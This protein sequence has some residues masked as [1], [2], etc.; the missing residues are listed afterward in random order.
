MCNNFNLGYFTFLLNKY[1]ICFIH[2]RC[3]KE[4]VEIRDG[5][6][7]LSPLIGRYCTSAP[8][9]QYST[10]NMIFIKFFT[11]TDEP[12]NGFKAKISL[13][14]CGGTLRGNTGRI[15]FPTPSG[16]HIKERKLNCTWHIVGPNDHYLEIKITKLDMNC[17]SSAVTVYDEI[18]NFNSSYN[19]K[20]S[21]YLIYAFSNIF[22]TNIYRMYIIFLK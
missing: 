3:K 22:N 4:Y 20:C 16:S 11:D 14:I 7:E 18:M 9:T 5:G 12:K 8:S 15:V 1:D 21:I 6:T 10:D 13:G 2:F 17:F 19:C